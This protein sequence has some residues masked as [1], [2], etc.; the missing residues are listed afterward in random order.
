MVDKPE[1]DE[2]KTASDEEI[3]REIFA[4]SREDLAKPSAQQ[5]EMTIQ[6]ARQRTGFADFIVLLLRTGKT[7]LSVLGLLFRSGG[8]PG[9]RE[10]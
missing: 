8:R 9:S 6:R 7:A 10:E 1:F 2:S 3:V 4:E 5:R